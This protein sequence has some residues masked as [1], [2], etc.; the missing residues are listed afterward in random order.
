[1]HGQNHIKLHECMFPFTIR[2]VTVN[3]THDKRPGNREMMP[4]TKRDF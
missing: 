4:G 3:G 1:M 2:N